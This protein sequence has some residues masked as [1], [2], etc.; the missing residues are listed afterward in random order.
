MR[1]MP[2]LAFG[3][4]A[5]GSIGRRDG[6]PLTRPAEVV[7]WHA[8][9]PPPSSRKSRRIPNAQSF[10]RTK[11]QGIRNALRDCPASGKAFAMRFLNVGV[12]VTTVLGAIPEILE[13]RAALERLFTF[14]V[15]ELDGLKE[16][17]LALGHAYGLHRASPERV[18][19]VPELARSQRATR[20]LLHADANALAARGLLDSERVSSLR[21]NKAHRLV[22]FDVLALVELF[23]QSWGS[24]REK[25]ALTLVEL[26]RAQKGANQLLLALGTRSRAKPDVVP[27]NLIYRQLYTRVVR[28]YAEVRCGLQFLRR[29]QGDAEAIAPSLFPAT[30]KRGRR[31]LRGES[32]SSAPP[33]V[34]GVLKKESS[35]DL[36]KQPGSAAWFARNS[37]A[38][39]VI[40]D[41]WIDA[42][43]MPNNIS[44][45]VRDQ[46]L[47]EARH[48]QNFSVAVALAL[49]ATLG[50]AAESES[51]GEKC[52]VNA[53]C[54]SGSCMAKG[55]EGFGTCYVNG[56]AC[57]EQ[58]RTV[59]SCDGVTR[60]G[61]GC[62]LG[63]CRHEGRC[64]DS[65]GAPEE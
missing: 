39:K 54:A 53:D 25:T 4:V 7:R 43:G 2:D 29:K 27:D 1:R 63:R 23:L 56:Q 37:S 3:N 32:S 9:C 11:S 21:G 17:T 41:S 19:V 61:S 49:W 10:V 33:P 35:A 48:L 64:D 15:G 31:G 30:R 55:C 12:V 24:I 46:L 8:E 20:A 22:A 40:A 65:G 16:P 42:T 51:K 52:K 62:E 45:A 26:M 38:P 50:C 44:K 6:K 59:C 18:D 60:V 14:D 36:S 58:N 34:S 28:T 5:G 47:V 57:A 13:H